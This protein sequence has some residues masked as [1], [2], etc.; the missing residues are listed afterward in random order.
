MKYIW[1]AYLGAKTWHTISESERKSSVDEFFAYDEV[2]GKNR[3]TIGG[4]GLQSAQNAL[5]LRFQKGKTIITDGPFAETKEQ[6][7]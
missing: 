4:Q 5:T 6:L 7:A 2:L 3:H 1:L